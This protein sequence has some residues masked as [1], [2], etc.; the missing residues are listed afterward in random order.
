MKNHKFMK[1]KRN[2]IKNWKKK[3]NEL[4]DLN[5]ITGKL[6]LT[7]YKYDDS[8]INTFTK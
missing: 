3:N 8:E 5:C 6:W 1:K 4:T 2:S 7:C